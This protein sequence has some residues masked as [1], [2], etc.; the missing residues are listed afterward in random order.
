MAVNRT[1]YKPNLAHYQQGF[2]M[3]ELLVAILLLSIGVLGLMQYQQ[4]LMASER[5]LTYQQ[6]LWQI[7]RQAWQLAPFKSSEQEMTEAVALPAKWQLR[8]SSQVE[9][10][11]KIIKISVSTPKQNRVQVFTAQVQRRVC[12]KNDR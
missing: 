9:N 6:Q 5:R 12:P 4:S 2:S 1:G 10:R 8:L 7:T 11:C 3:I